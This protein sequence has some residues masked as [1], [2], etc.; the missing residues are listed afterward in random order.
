[1][2]AI[3][4]GVANGP[5]RRSPVLVGV[6]GLNLR[7]LPCEPSAARPLPHP[8]HHAALCCPSSRLT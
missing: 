3:A 7:A 2:L 5:A 8:V 1:V 4:G 6:A